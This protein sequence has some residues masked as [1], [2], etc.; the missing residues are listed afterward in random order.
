ML[1]P[2]RSSTVSDVRNHC[3]RLSSS[4]IIKLSNHKD[5]IGLWDFSSLVDWFDYFWAMFFWWFL[6]W[7]VIIIQHPNLYYCTELNLILNTWSCYADF[8]NRNSSH[9]IQHIS[10][11][12]AFWFI[13][14]Q[15]QCGFNPTQILLIIT[16]LLY[17]LKC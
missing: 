16:K 13:E 2:C 8:L 5:L 7:H 14:G 4:K 15:A 9:N 12:L 10:W 11:E 17:L 3:S 1:F 6:I